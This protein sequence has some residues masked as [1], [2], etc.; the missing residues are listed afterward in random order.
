MRR[1]LMG[2]PPSAP[3]VY[4][5]VADDRRRPTGGFNGTL[6]IMGADGDQYDDDEGADAEGGGDFRGFQDHS[7]L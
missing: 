5:W 2:R 7:N 4:A 6:D 3:A 1:M